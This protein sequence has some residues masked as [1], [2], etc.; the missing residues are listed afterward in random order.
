MFS[1]LVRAFAI[2]MVAL[3][4]TPARALAQS[5][6]S[7]GP[8]VPAILEVP[9]GH[10]VFFQARAH[11]TQNYMCLPTGSG[12]AWTLVGPQATL[13]S[14]TLAGDVRHQR[15]THFAS[16]NPTEAGV[17]RPTWQHSVDTSRV[18]GRALQVSTD[19]AFVAPDAI[20]WLLLESVGSQAG[21]VGGSFLTQTA[22]IQRV[23]KAGGR[24]PAGGCGQASEIGRM[25]L[26][27]YAADYYFYGAGRGR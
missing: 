16:A 24:A 18:W 19:S 2:C 11:G 8:S 17:T 25:V 27:P 15:S 10:T 6:P 26:V 1:Y 13:Y 7:G 20:P 23:N 21:P 9:A 14:T 12:Q 4:M 5:G 22:Y 3:G